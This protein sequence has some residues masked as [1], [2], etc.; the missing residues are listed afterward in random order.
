VI[1]VVQDA[2]E[3][4]LLIVSL[5]PNPTSHTIKLVSLAQMSP[6]ISQSIP[7]LGCVKKSVVMVEDSIQIHIIVM[8]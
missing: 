1:K 2:L 5:V 8:T 7:F 3:L 6:D 4:L